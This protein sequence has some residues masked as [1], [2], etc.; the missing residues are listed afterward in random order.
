MAKCEHY[1]ISSPSQDR[2]LTCNELS[3]TK[4]CQSC[5]DSERYLEEV[6]GENRE[7]KEED[8]QAVAIPTEANK[9]RSPRGSPAPFPHGGAGTT[10]DTHAEADSE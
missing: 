9:K 8:Y 5:V 2:C 4:V 10:R 7:E 3:T 1:D 6:P